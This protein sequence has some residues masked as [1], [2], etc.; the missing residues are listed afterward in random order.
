MDKKF[1]KRLTRDTQYF[2]PSQTYQETLTNQ[3]IKDKLK[4]YK[5][6]VDIKTVSLGT[7]IRYFS[8]DS[9]TKEK[10]FRLGGSLTK[11]DPEGKYVV[12]SNGTVS[13]SV[14]IPHAIFF[15]K[16]SETELKDE[17]KKEI[18]K[19]MMTE[20]HSPNEDVEILK[21]EIKN[22][23]LKLEQHKNTE[24]EYKKKNESLNDKLSTIENEI[25]KS[26]NKK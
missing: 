13:W 2:R 14:Q 5:K 22:L 17:L 25:K 24:K 4:D 23:K 6:V 11:I 3:D 7:H 12:L 21:K 18:K 8:V 9:K 20:T 10:T 19:E 1:T 16:L 26:K 15:Q